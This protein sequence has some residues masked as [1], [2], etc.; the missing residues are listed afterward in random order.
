[1]GSMF[2]PRP[3]NEAQWTNGKRVV[4]GRWLYNWASDR[5][6][7]ELDQKDRT[8]GADTKRFHVYGDSPEWGKWKR[9]PESRSEK[10][11]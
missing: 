11:E 2:S 3:M 6:L 9:I 1:M 4:S 5:F 7:V 10:H 8:T